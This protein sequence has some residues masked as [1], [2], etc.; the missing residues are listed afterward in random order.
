MTQEQ[1]LAHRRNKSEKRQACHKC[2]LATNNSNIIGKENTNR[3]EQI[4]RED[5]INKKNE[6]S[7]ACQLTDDDHN[8]LKKF[9]DAV[10]ELKYNYCPICKEF[11]FSIPL[12]YKTG[13]CDRCSRDKLIQ[14]RFSLEN[15]KDS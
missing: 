8:L 4:N 15:N 10:A 2:Q 7:P 6:V 5:N 1:Q 9:H 11:F 14:K 3:D 13:N 12:N